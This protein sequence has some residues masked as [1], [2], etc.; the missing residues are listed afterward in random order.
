MPDIAILQQLEQ[1]YPYHRNNTDEEV[2]FSANYHRIMAL[3][4][5]FKSNSE[6][7]EAPASLVKLV[8]RCTEYQ[9][10][11]LRNCSSAIVYSEWI[12]S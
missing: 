9:L 8:R 12:L 5:E 6:L 11:V 1:Q 4:D 7:L 2:C 10:S 3:L